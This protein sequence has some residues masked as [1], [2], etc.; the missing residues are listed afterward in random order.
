MVCIPC[1]LLPFMGVLV[2]LFDYI[3]PFLVKIGLLKPS[4][5]VENAPPP[6]SKTTT[7]AD[8]ANNNKAKAT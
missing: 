8:N 7:T 4:P 5:K 1:L 3:K 6:N 2:V